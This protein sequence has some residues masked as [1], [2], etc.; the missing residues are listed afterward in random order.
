MAGSLIASTGHAKY[1]HSTGSVRKAYRGGRIDVYGGAAAPATADAAAVGTKLYSI[2]NNAASAAVKQKITFTPTVGTA[3]AAVWNIILNGITHSYTDDGTATPTEICDGLRALITASM[4]GALTTPAG[5]IGI[6]DVASMFALTGTATLIVEAATAGVPFDYSASVSGA[7][8][9]TGSWA[10]EIT[11]ADAYGLEFEDASDIAA[12]ILE[13]LA[14]Q[15]WSGVAVA[16]GTPTYFRL[17]QS[18]DTG[19][20][21][22]TLPRLQGTI[23]TVAGAAMVVSNA[24]VALGQTIYVDSAAFNIPL[25]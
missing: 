20:L 6:P 9:G 19:A 2:T 10:T 4:G 1:L 25:T 14:S 7:G 11:T 24:T 13:K 23:S 8:A 17:V 15:T 3:V 21:S 16:A 18:A 5:T 22:T 12:G